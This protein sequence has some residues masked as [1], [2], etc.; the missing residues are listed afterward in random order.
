MKKITAIAINFF[1]FLLAPLALAQSAAPADKKTL[2][3]AFGPV[4]TNLAQKSGYNTGTSF[5]SILGAVISLIL[6]VLGVIFIVLIVYGGI[7]W[8]TAAGNDERAKKAGDI[9][10]QSAIGLIIVVAAYILTYFLIKFFGGQLA[11]TP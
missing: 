7:L 8:M 11:P 2:R 6:S 5:T 9:L 1:S 10:K 4:F 3:D